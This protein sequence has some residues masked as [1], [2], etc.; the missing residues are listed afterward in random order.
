M[1]WIF[2]AELWF[3]HP[4]KMHQKRSIC[5]GY[6]YKSGTLNTIDQVASVRL[7]CDRTLHDNIT[8]IKSG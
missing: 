2:P 1:I 5:L 6:N 4:E 8:A 7:R 3:I